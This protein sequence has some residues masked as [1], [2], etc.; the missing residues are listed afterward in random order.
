[1]KVQSYQARLQT[2]TK[3]MSKTQSDLQT[4]KN[5]ATAQTQ[6]STLNG[7]ESARLRELEA[8]YQQQMHQQAEA[9]QRQEQANMQA[10]FERRLAEALA[11]QNRE[12]MQE[13]QFDP[14]RIENQEMHS[15]TLN[16]VSLDY[17]NRTRA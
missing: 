6:P 5:R 4:L 11:A 15:A 3:S 10:E 12:Q 13:V 2:Q 1:M 8:Q 7:R 16:E 17:Q 9:W 14:L